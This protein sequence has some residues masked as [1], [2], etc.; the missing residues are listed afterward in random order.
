MHHIIQYLLINF[1]ENSHLE[2]TL[3]VLECLDYIEKEIDTIAKQA[4]KES[5]LRHPQNHMA[6]HLAGY[7]S[8]D[9]AKDHLL[10]LVGEVK[11]RFQ[12][13]I[14][15]DTPDLR[16]AAIQTFLLNIND[17]EVGCMEARLRPALLAS[18]LFES[19]GCRNLHDLMHEF[20]TKLTTPS[21]IATTIE[22]ILDFF[23]DKVEYHL[24]VFV[25]NKGIQTLTWQLIKNYLKLILDYE[26]IEKDWSQ[27]G[28]FLLTPS[29]TNA[30]EIVKTPR[31]F[32]H[33]FHEKQEA[34]RYLSYIKSV[35]PSYQSELAKT[36][37]QLNIMRQTYSF[38]LS[39]E[40]YVAFISLQKQEIIEQIPVESLFH[41]IFDGITGVNFTNKTQLVCHFATHQQAF[42]SFTAIK[43]LPPI[44]TNIL[45][46]I[47]ANPVSR[48]SYSLTVLEFELLRE[49]IRQSLT[50]RLPTQPFVFKSLRVDPLSYFRHFIETV[51]APNKKYP[52]RQS[53]KKKYTVTAEG[54]FR[55]TSENEEMLSTHIPV[56]TPQYTPF[57]KKGFSKAQPAS[58]GLPDL[59]SPIFGAF[60]RD[61]DLVG[62]MFL[63]MENNTLLTDRNYTVDIGSVGR[64]Y[65]FDSLEAAQAYHQQKS[66]TTLFS[67]AQFAA[68]QTAIKN[69]ANQYNELLVRIRWT[70]DKNCQIFIGSDSL[71]ARL[72]AQEYA[73]ILKSYLLTY[74]LCDETYTIPLCF[75]T[76]E[77]QSLIFKEYHPN[78]Q[79]IDQLLAGAIY[80]SKP[81]REKNFKRNNYAILMAQ[82]DNELL[83]LFKNSRIIFDL[84]SKNYFHI[85]HSLIEK[86]TRTNEISED[87]LWQ[88][89]INNP[90]KP[91]RK[92]YFSTV[93]IDAMN[94]V[95][96]EDE[97]LIKL[98]TQFSKTLTHASAQRVLHHAVFLSHKTIVQE[99]LKNKAIDLN[100]LLP[101]SSRTYLQWA[102][103]HGHLDILN[104]LLAHE[105][106]IDVNFSST[107][108][109]RDYADIVNLITKELETSFLFHMILLPGYLILMPLVLILSPLLLISSFDYEFSE[110]YSSEDST[111][112]IVGGTALHGAVLNGQIECVKALLGNRHL[113]VNKCTMKGSITPLHL[114]L[115]NNHDAITEILLAHPGIQ[116]NSLALCWIKPTGKSSAE[117]TAVTPVDLAFYKKNF[118][119]A[120]RL[121]EHPKMDCIQMTPLTCSGLKELAE[122]PEN[123]DW[124]VSLLQNYLLAY[125]ERL[126][127]QDSRY[128]FL[129]SRIFGN[130]KQKTLRAVQSLIDKQSS[131]SEVFHQ[132]KQN[133]SKGE[134]GR[135]YSV[136][137]KLY[138]GKPYQPPINPANLDSFDMNKCSETEPLLNKPLNIREV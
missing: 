49:T 22:T 113:D 39:Y 136:L 24:P 80:A 108:S 31:W 57:E 42:T 36:E 104:Q 118:L 132:H 79:R 90:H 18:A 126:R 6:F 122:N 19:N 26:T 68:F 48:L 82:P 53:P 110:P 56:K 135:V 112:K 83:S 23:S 51:N 116:V 33:N 12:E 133:L 21:D 105:A 134:L 55:R 25:E 130:H 77:S 131:L 63:N 37:V 43:K 84:F 100:H 87:Q 34:G 120:R 128:N 115:E 137:V 35:L 119:L 9:E 99:L 10:K 98:V 2:I 29:L 106:A 69:Q 8:P 138:E 123:F 4:G 7:Q 127:T 107:L 58:L 86:C 72:W 92:N 38:C 13:L 50:P 111:Q 5:L 67:K 89:L 91:T 81:L 114:A 41:T 45:A 117:R 59:Y 73:R 125:R 1:S 64:P 40:Q 78:E 20:N 76:P 96:S 93:L 71:S 54:I 85:V 30:C 70:P 16:Q 102:A 60:S 61:D 47:K 32:F 44:R 97:Q 11:G 121:L 95:P 94:S 14:A 103:D 74:Q 124:I 52:V 28:K 88:L 15:I 109:Q 75:Y 101:G 17:S 3:R 62:V 129:Q 46:K 27:Y 66:G 65:D